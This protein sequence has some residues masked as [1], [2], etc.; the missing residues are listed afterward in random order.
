MLNSE[1]C[2]DKA[3]TKNLRSINGDHTFFQGQWY[4]YRASSTPVESGSASRRPQYPQENS[5][6]SES[7]KSAK[8]RLKMRSLG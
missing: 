3:K 8:I 5:S 6:K 2:K 7:G 1:F 4:T